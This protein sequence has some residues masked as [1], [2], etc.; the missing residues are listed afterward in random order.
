MLRHQTRQIQAVGWYNRFYFWYSHEMRATNNGLMYLFIYLYTRYKRFC[1]Y[2]Y[3]YIYICH[4]VFQSAMIPWAVYGENYVEHVSLEYEKESL[5]VSFNTLLLK[6]NIPKTVNF[7]DL[8]WISLQTI[9]KKCN[10]KKSNF[11]CNVFQM[12]LHTF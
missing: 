5:L 11:S 4:L 12:I 2:I 3:I 1:I 9:S 6:R 10:F 8:H 7:D